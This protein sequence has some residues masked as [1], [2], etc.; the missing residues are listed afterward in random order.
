[1]SLRHQYLYISL[2]ELLNLKEETEKNLNELEMKKNLYQSMHIDSINLKDQIHDRTKSFQGIESLIIQRDTPEEYKNIKSL[3]SDQCKELEF[4]QKS[5]KILPEE[6]KS[7]KQK[8]DGND[9]N[10]LQQTI[11]YKQCQHK[12]AEAQKWLGENSYEYTIPKYDSDRLHQETLD[13]MIFINELKITTP[14]EIQR[15]LDGCECG[16]EYPDDFDWLS[17]DVW[18]EKPIGEKVS[19]CKCTQLAGP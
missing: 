6:I 7:I 16:W 2:E 8:L 12:L 10:I 11:L 3:H 4:I 17:Y 19:H 18:S 5:L 9:I 13:V 15:K 1:M 14:I